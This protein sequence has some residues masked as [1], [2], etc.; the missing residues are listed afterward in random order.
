MF[1]SVEVST[2]LHFCYH[3]SLSIPKGEAKTTGCP[4]SH[5]AKVQAYC[6][7]CDHLIH[8]IS[9][10]ITHVHGSLS[11][12]FFVSRNLNTYVTL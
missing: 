4:K 10:G 11:Y 7:A 8:K 6:S 9:S 12:V 3:I 5:C 2:L 1:L